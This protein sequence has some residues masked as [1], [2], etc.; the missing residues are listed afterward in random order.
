MP[1]D[2]AVTT[3]AAPGDFDPLTISGR[4]RPEAGAAASTAWSGSRPKVGRWIY[5]R[6]GRDL[7]RCRRRGARSRGRTIAC[8]ES[9]TGGLLGHRLTDVPGSSAYFR[10]WLRR[11][12]QRAKI[13]RLGV[14]AGFIQRHGA[15]SAPVAGA[16]ARGF[17]S[18]R[19]DFGLAVTGIA[20]PGGGTPANRSGSSISPWPGPAGTRRTA[21]LLRRAETGQVPVLA[22]SP[23]H[24]REIT[25]SRSRRKGHIIGSRDIH[26]G[27][28]RHRPRSEHQG[29][30]AGPFRRLR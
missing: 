10:E 29:E 4:G 8:A 5:S 23:G 30:P 1:P 14:P 16:M 15:V 24:A 28:H 6:D 12:R 26:A 27:L 9:C 11:L 2:P 3:L 20:G 19:R 7:S 25:L 21:D 22:E 17:A 13:R 18:L